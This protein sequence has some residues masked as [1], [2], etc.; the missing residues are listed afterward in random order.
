MNTEDEIA[1]MTTPDVAKLIEELTGCSGGVTGLRL[2][3][4]DNIRFCR[5]DEQ[6]ADGKKWDRPGKPA[7][8]WRGAADG[9]PML[10]DGIIQERVEI[11]QAAFWRSAI[12]PK[13]SETEISSYATALAEHYLQS[14]MTERL[15]GEV[16][17]SANHM[18][19]YGRVILHPRWE[20]EISL[21]RVKVTMADIER[22]T[23]EA[24]QQAAAAGD[25]QFRLSDLPL[26][27]ADEAQEDGAIA[28]LQ[29]LYSFWAQRYI[30]T[31]ID[32]PT[33]RLKD[34]TARKAIQSLRK[35]GQAQIPTPYLAKNGPVIYALKFWDEVW[36]PEET[37]DL[38][39]ARIIFHREWLTQ[40]E[41]E[42]REHSGWDPDWI[43]LA[44]KTAGMS[45]DP[46]EMT[47]K[48]GGSAL[49]NIGSAPVDVLSRSGGRLI[50]VMSA[51][52]KAVDSDGVLGVYKTTFSAHIKRGQDQKFPYAI[53][54]LV[55]SGRA[56]YP[57][58]GGRAEHWCRQFAASRGVP[59]IVQT[60]QS[61]AKTLDDSV[62][63]FT[64]IA[65]LPP[66]NVPKV[67]PTGS[68]YRFGPAVQNEIMPG[69]EPQFMSIPTSGASYALTARAALHERVANH[70]GLMHP[71][72]SPARWQ[73]SQSIRAQAFLLLWSR[74]L[75]QV[76]DLA[77][78]YMPDVDFSAITG[79]P[80][81]WL[82]ARR[83][84]LGMLA[85]KLDFDVSELDGEITLKRIEAVNRTILP[86]DV[87]GVIDRTAWIRVMVRAVNPKWVRDLIMPSGAASQQMFDGVR[88]DIAQM[89]L[90]NEAKYVEN[91][92]AAKSKLQF[93][94]QIV[95]ANPNYTAALQQG[96]RFAELMEKWSKNLQFSVTQAENSQVGRIGVTPGVSN[97]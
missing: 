63:D 94:T 16:A 54:E 43:A 37:G 25:S 4:I 80:I 73:A 42:S 34:A 49:A 92:P 52:Y 45:Y 59:Q 51:I 22:F 41:L 88:N 71:N 50:E 33:P 65:V 68:K 64:S 29:A 13:S 69:R 76:I 11:L 12:A 97:E 78:Q 53:S 83:G 48:T 26:M 47:T 1:G 62:V 67:G 93:A 20:R 61:E 89:F 31:E 44:V 10:A 24:E 21:R 66:V 84:N 57:Y 82:E 14:E 72:V 2:D 60:W 75:Q 95:Q 5:W 36:A 27:V 28:G 7:F 85:V 86:A 19:Q 77:V 17:L 3:E 56:E 87:Q 18:E 15:I 23:K 6:S 79:A 55:S 96:G 74:A 70:F 38:S 8:P 40:A 39:S 35:T 90:G 91:D 32:L 9:R 46:Q 81:G 30:P 58:I